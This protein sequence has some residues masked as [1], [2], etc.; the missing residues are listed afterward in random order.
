MDG[1]RIT[2]LRPDALIAARCWSWGWFT[3][4]FV[5][6]QALSRLR[7]SSRRD[8]FSPCACPVKKT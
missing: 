4:I 2:Y 6:R 3:P 5:S 1:V 8:L 7:G